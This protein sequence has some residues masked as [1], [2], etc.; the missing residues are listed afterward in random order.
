MAILGVAFSVVGLIPLRVD[1]VEAAAVAF[2]VVGLVALGVGTR[3]PAPW[4]AR[5][6]FKFDDC[7][8]GV[9]VA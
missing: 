5:A 3:V 7:S 6:R 2:G 1:E 8:R 9:S 4:H